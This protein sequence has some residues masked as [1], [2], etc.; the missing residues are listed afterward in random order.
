[1][2]VTESDLIIKLPYRVGLWISRADDAPGIMD[3]KVERAKLK[4][5]ITKVAKY[6]ESSAFV[7]TTLANTLSHT[8]DW[9][10][11]SAGLDTILADCAQGLDIFKAQGR[12]D[13]LKIYRAVLMQ[14][15]IC[16][17]EAFQEE[18]P[19]RIKMISPIPLPKTANDVG[20]P[21]NISQKEKKALD[22][23]KQVLWA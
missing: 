22:S 15:A 12:E 21:E 16:V 19:E 18:I 20:I 10:N 17:A 9:L 3:E 7:R 1:M 13:D 14:T 11:W 2:A 5:V 4:D 23:L 6:H 8:T